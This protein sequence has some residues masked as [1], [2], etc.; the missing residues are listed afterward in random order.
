MINVLIKL[1]KFNNFFILQMIKMK[2][3]YCLIFLYIFKAY[4]YLT[5]FNLKFIRLILNSKLLIQEN[6]LDQFL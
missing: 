4:F 3:Y 6:D 2:L 5:I 1:A